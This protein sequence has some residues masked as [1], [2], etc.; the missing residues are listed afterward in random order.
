MVHWD[1]PVRHVAR[2]RWTGSPPAQPRSSGRL[3]GVKDVGAQVGQAVARRRA[4]G[5]GLGGDVGQHRPV[6][7]LRPRRSTRSRRSS[8]ATR[9]RHEVTTYSKERM[10]RASRPDEGRDHRPAVRHR[11]RRPAPEGRRG[12]G[13]DRRP[14][15]RLERH[16][17]LAARRADDGDRGRPGQGQGGRHQARRGPPGG[18]DAA[19]RA[20]GRATCSRTRRCST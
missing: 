9:A 14:R 10:S 3:P 5:L 20:A 8:P 1:A 15:R 2:P 7:A 11:P 18:G 13:R 19:L 4:G 17:R 12:E 16:R 6:G